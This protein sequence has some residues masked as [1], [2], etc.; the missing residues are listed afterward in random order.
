MLG[1]LVITEMGLL[2]PCCINIVTAEE[3]IEVELFFKAAQALLLM[4]L[5]PVLGAKIK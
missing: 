2:H 4:V 5:H 1:L 3:V